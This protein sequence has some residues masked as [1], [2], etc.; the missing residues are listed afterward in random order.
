MA[1]SSRKN[2]VNGGKT[3]HESYK[4]RRSFRSDAYPFCVWL[5]VEN[6]RE[7]DGPS[8]PAWGGRAHRSTPLA[9]DPLQ[10]L[11][12]AGLHVGQVT[13]Q[14]ARQRHREAVV[15]VVQGGQPRV[16]SVV[17]HILRGKES[18]SMV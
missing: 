16:G 3:G 1:C 9:F 4:H 11:I 17:L 8:L 18:M 12:V 14:A 7:V 2:Q 13:L 5:C 15:L 10:Q 6:S